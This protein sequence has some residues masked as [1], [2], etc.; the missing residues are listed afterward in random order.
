VTLNHNPHT[1]Y[2]N[3]MNKYVELPEEIKQVK[4]EVDSYLA[5]DFFNYRHI[6]SKSR[7]QT[8]VKDWNTCHH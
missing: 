1:P 6:L 4:T 3:K 8:G 7:W 5:T 2:S